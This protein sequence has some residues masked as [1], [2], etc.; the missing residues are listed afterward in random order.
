MTEPLIITDPELLKELAKRVIPGLLRVVKAFAPTIE[1]S[2]G[3]KLHHE[4]TLLN[5]QLCVGSDRA[6]H[7]AVVQVRLSQFCKKKSALR[8]AL[9]LIEDK[10][11][12]TLSYKTVTDWVKTHAETLREASVGPEGIRLTVAP[13]IVELCLAPSSDG[14]L[15]NQGILQAI[16]D[17]V[18]N[19]LSGPWTL[20]DIPDGSGC[21][22]LVVTPSGVRLS[23]FL[24]LGGAVAQLRL[25]A[26]ML[27]KGEQVEVRV[28]EGPHGDRIV[29]LQTDTTEYLANQYFRVLAL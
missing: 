9:V 18:G 22:T 2:D 13:R 21:I 27:P 4:V 28:F 23:P 16:N 29:H 15:Y 12:L 7:T 1:D 20:P 10:V 24:E 6:V 17:R 5:G 26:G 25:K 19:P 8:D 3:K 11:S 14:K